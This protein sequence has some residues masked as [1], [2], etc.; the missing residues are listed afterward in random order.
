MPDSEDTSIWV[1]TLVSQRTGEG[2]VQ[3][4]WYDHSAQ[5]TPAEARG[6]AQQ[7]QEAAAVTET[8]AFLVHFAETKV[9]MPKEE[10][11]MILNEFR[12]YRAEQEEKDDRTA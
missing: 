7:L 2:L 1:E 10:A 6:L 4:A 9:G 12:K 5:M 8:D 11:C 3:I